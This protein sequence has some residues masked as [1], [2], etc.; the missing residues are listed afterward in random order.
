[1]PIVGT[2]AAASSQ[3]FGEFAQSSAGAVNYIEQVFSTFLYTGNGS[4]QTI[5]NGIDLSTYGGM[6]WIKQRSATR[7][8]LLFDTS[9]GATQRLFSNLTLAQS[10]DTQSLTAF[11]SSGFSVGS[12]SGC[13]IRD[14]KSTRLNSSHT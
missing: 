6:T 12:D 10:Q 1:M 14:R 9:R 13:N 2:K 8:N 11:T 7:D 4:T 5:T 3:G